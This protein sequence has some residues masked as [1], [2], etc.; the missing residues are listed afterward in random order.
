MYNWKTVN[1]HGKEA[2]VMFLTTSRFY[3]LLS[4]E[5]VEN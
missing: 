3:A 2:C 4:I 5:Q 1:Q